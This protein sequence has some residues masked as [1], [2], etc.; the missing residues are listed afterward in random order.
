MKQSSF[1][2]EG[3]ALLKGRIEECNGNFAGEMRPA[4]L[5]LFSF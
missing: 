4:F 2:V 3:K 5:S 1:G